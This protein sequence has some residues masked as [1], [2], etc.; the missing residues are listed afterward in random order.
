[1][2]AE[3]SAALVRRWVAL[4]T[5]GLPPAARQ[6]RRDEIDD[7]LWCQAQEAATENRADGSLAGEMVARL[8]FGVPSDVSWRIEQGLFGTARPAHERSHAMNARPPATLALVGGASWLIFLALA[9]PSG[10][11][12]GRYKGDPILMLALLLGGTVALVIATVRLVAAAQDM[13]SGRTATVAVIGAMVVAI[14]VFGF[15]GVFVGP[16]VGSAMVVWQLGRAGVLPV[17]PSRA[18]FA[19]AIIIVVDAVI[20]KISPVLGLYGVLLLLVAIALYAFTWVAIGW[21]LRRNRSAASDGAV[22]AGAA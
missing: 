6:D 2:N 4:Y 20:G 22:G 19:A 12:E 15:L 21:S 1:M 9:L 5:L 17:W 13:I 18:Q 3:R 8:L 7:D 14:V 16:V 10:F 11:L